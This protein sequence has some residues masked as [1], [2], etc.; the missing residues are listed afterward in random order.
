MRAQLN[1]PG[2]EIAWGYM[3]VHNLNF[4]KAT[5]NYLKNVM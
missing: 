2:K 3:K 4:E 1:K 5:Q